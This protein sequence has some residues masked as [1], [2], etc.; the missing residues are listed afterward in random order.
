MNCSPY[1]EEQIVFI[2]VSSF[3]SYRDIEDNANL[4]YSRKLVFCII[5]TAVPGEPSGLTL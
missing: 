2:G 1:H 5:K 3:S 4:H